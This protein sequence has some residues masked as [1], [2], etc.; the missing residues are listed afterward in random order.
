MKKGI[1]II[2][3]V[4]GA[5][6]ALILI[7]VV[8]LQTN[9]GKNFVRQKVVEYLNKKL[10][11]VVQIDK[12]NYKIPTFLELNGVLFLDTQNDTMLQLKKLRVDIDM[13][14]L[15]QNKVEVNGILLE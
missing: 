14:A 3:Y 1:K 13:F 15:I 5:I 6:L 2:L 8:A 7:A 10:N 4:I 11:T 12:L 9:M